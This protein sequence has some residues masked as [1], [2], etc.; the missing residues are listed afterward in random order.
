MEPI[1]SDEEM[2]AHQEY[3]EVFSL[4]TL[5]DDFF[6]PKPVSTTRPLHQRRPSGQK[7]RA[8]ITP[9]EQVSSVCAALL[10]GEARAFREAL[11]MAQADHAPGDQR[12]EPLSWGAHVTAIFE[13]IPDSL[14]LYD[15]EGRLVYANQAAWKLFA[16]NRR[17]GMSSLKLR[18]LA[19][20]FQVRDE[21]GKP[22]PYE[23]W[24]LA[25]ILHGE[26]IPEAR[27]EKTLIRSLDGHDLLLSES[28]CPLYSGNHQLMGAALISK[29]ARATEQ[30]QD[31]FLALI[32]HELRSPLTT[33]L[34]YTEIL[35]QKTERGAGGKLA[36][37]Q[38]EALETISR[39]AMQ[40]VELT[41]DLLD[42]A[43]LRAGVLEVHRCDADLVAL[44]Q[45]V[46]TRVQARARRHTISLQTT[47]RHIVGALDVQGI[48]R[49]LTNLLSNAV[50]Y[51]PD[52]SEIL[53]TITEGPDAQ[54]VVLAI[55][56]QGIGIPK[57]Q[58]PHIFRRFFRADNA[59]ARG[60]DGTGLGL[61]L[62]R[63][64]IELHNGR[65]WFESA[66]GK[67][68]TF[69]VALPLMESQAP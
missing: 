1:R 15:H 68:S 53:L 31:D 63:A 51:S 69:Y 33:L 10:P 42:V 39:D 64:L 37:W 27:A 14:T 40:L 23:W 65:L 45:R 17:A 4:P 46:V 58:Q 44:A 35:R 6:V 13:A 8:E 34:G 5:I 52:A 56:D 2:R 55:H 25:R 66:E 43:R 18:E 50:K 41:N 36:G 49:V 60:I 3:P 16:L 38:I 30:L 26:Q 48:E 28:G 19:R 24:S 20:L 32:A 57:S 11:P 54:V 47:A 67:G 61:Y 7:G 62:C 59:R 22:L 9:E 21:D 12:C 29:T